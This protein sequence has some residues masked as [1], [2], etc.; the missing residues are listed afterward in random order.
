MSAS[1]DDP[2]LIRAELPGDHG[3]VFEVVRRAFEGEGEAELVAALRLVADPQISLVA[4]REERVVGHV[5]FSPV[6][7]EG[8]RVRTT[9]LGLAPLAVAPECQRQGIGSALVRAGLEAARRAGH[10]VVVVLGHPGFYPRFGFRP[11]G[12][13]GLRYEAPG[14][15]EAFLVV[16]LTAGA[17][18]D[19]AGVVR[20]RPEFA[21]F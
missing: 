2:V 13:R 10:G 16:E 11:A 14:H 18:G 6:T 12:A 19:A 15:D 8:E 17:L 9:A 4:L 21:R 3:A 7:I 20:Y 1:L 5:F